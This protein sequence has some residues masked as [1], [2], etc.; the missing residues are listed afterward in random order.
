MEDSDVCIDG[1]CLH[2]H[3]YQGHRFVMFGL[4]VGSDAAVISMAV[5]ICVAVKPPSIP[6]RCTVCSAVGEHRLLSTSYIVEI[7]SVFGDS[8]LPVSR[9]SRTAGRSSAICPTSTAQ[10]FENL[11]T[12]FLS[13]FSNICSI[14]LAG[15]GDSWSPEHCLS[16]G[17]HVGLVTLPDPQQ[18]LGTYGQS[19]YVQP[20]SLQ[21]MCILC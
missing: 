11:W 1:E 14:H 7:G 20:I 4:E 12:A 17:N 19:D 15:H 18:N 9:S 5:G 16:W 10:S 3:P 2:D 6:P 21:Y 13:A 8:G